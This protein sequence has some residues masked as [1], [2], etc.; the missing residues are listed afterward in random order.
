MIT[1]KLNNVVT[2]MTSKLELESRHMAVVET[3]KIKMNLLPFIKEQLTYDNPEYVNAIRMG[4]FITPELRKKKFVLGWSID[5]EG[6]LVLPRAFWHRLKRRLDHHIGLDYQV[7]DERV[8]R[9]VRAP[10]RYKADVRLRPYQKAAVERAV[11]IGEGMIIAPCGSGKT[12]ILTDIIRRLNQWTIVLVHTDDL[13]QQMKSRLEGALGIRVGVIKQDL[14]DIQ[15]ITVASIATLYRRGDEI[16]PQEAQ[17]SAGGLRIIERVPNKGGPRKAALWRA[18]DFYKLWGMVLIDEAHHAP[19]N[20]IHTVVS[21]FHALYRL[22]C[23]ATE[24]RRDNLEGLMFATVGYR[25]FNITH[26]ELYD[27]GYLMRAEVRPI[28]TSFEFY[29]WNRRQYQK[30]LKEL[31]NND[32][33]NTLIVNNILKEP[34]EFHLILSNQIN[35]LKILYNKLIESDPKLEQKASLLIGE[36]DGATRDVIIKGMRNGK[37]RYIFATQLADE[38]LDIPNLSR[39][40]LTFPSRAESKI[41]QQCGRVQRPEP[42]KTDAVVYDYVDRRVNVLNSQAQER[43]RVYKSAE[44]TIKEPIRNSAKWERPLVFR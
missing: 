30:L 27:A 10:Y 38:G 25:I 12:Q 35:H 21:K 32:E 1:I 28:E 14:F 19:A 43:I 16:V 20:S 42:D 37:I 36:M 8:S 23:T 15:P 17:D 6:N 22:G 7:V 29:N 40:H 39:V 9:P 2:V 26:K 13:L 11:D 33:R 3:N 24:R 31:V 5:N 34:N 18:E 4:M 41:L 44:Y